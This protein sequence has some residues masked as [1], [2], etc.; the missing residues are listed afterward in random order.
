MEVEDAIER[1]NAE[2]EF[3]SCAYSEQEAWC[4]YCDNDEHGDAPARVKR[5][6]LATSAENGETASF[7]VELRLPMDYP[8]SGCLQISGIV[9]EDRTVSCQ[10]KPAYDALPDL[11]EVCRETAESVPAGEE[12]I[13]TVLSQAEEWIQ[14]VW[15]T[16]RYAS[17]I[18][19]QNAIVQPSSAPSSDKAAAVL[20][21]TLIHSHHIIGKKKRADMK[22]LASEL[23][24]KLTG[25]IKIGWPGL[26]IIEGDGLSCQQFYDRIRRWQWQYLVLR[27]EMREELS[28][29]EQ[30][31]SRRKF[32]SFLEV[33]DM[34]LVAAHCR[35]V[36]LESLFLTSMKVY[37][38]SD[39]VETANAENLYGALVHV[40]HMNNGKAYR[41]WLR[42]TCNELDVALLLKQCYP[43][44][45]FSKRP[46]IVVG[47]VGSR[48]GVSSVLKKWRVSRVDDDS[49][50][51]PC[52]ERMMSVL[53]EGELD[54]K[55]SSSM[56]W[57]NLNSDS[58]LNTTKKK[59]IDVLTSTGIQSWV[60]AVDSLR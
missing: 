6:L 30:V 17:I 21:R 35:E 50:R 27:G 49:R 56:D 9:E 45:D 48:A 28:A 12:A 1:R 26:V 24:V 53:V 42:R 57:D 58:Q 8:V 46:L 34:S 43:H 36:G 20:G 3:V 13:F 47:L 5:R 44:E 59:L 18:K 39:N 41:K 37:A 51:K 60:E 16:Y 19:N 38:N 40:D 7:V 54:A 11:L 31:D 32:S 55:L 4:S 22:D 14:T 33:D 52:L 25:Y 10:L 15:P 23:T 29:N 2:L